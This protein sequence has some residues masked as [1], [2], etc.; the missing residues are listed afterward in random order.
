V[1]FYSGIIY[2]VLGIP[3]NMFTV[4]FAIARTVGWV[5]QWMEMIGDPEQRI[6]RPRQLYQ[7]AALRDYVEMNKRS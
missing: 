3:A 6:A 2:K 7:G 1:D 5:A 4:M